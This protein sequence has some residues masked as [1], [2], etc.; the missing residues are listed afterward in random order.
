[1]QARRFNRELEILEAEQE[2]S[3]TIFGKSRKVSFQCRTFIC[4]E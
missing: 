4:G 1:M 2:A 3:Q